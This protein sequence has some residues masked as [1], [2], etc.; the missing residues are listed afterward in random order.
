MWVPVENVLLLSHT[1]LRDGPE[2]LMSVFHW[3]E[4]LHR[5][6][7]QAGHLIIYFKSH[8]EAAYDKGKN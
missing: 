5:E 3:E 6:E 7:V 8:K 1:P 2:R 4:I